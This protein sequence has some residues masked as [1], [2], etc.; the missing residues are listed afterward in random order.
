ME[1]TIKPNYQISI[2]FELIKELKLSVN[3]KV[4]LKTVKGTIVI[5]KKKNQK[6]P[7]LLDLRGIIKVGPGNIQKD[8]EKMKN[9]RAKEI[10]D[11]LNE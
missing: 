9:I 8:I 4:E 2:P 3:D 1:A 10:A 6:K 11:S 5:S 7:S